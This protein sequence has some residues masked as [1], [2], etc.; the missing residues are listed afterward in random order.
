MKT[1]RRI[2]T[3]IL[4]IIFLICFFSESVAQNAI[5]DT[6]V[7]SPESRQTDSSFIHV[8]NQNH[9]VNDSISTDKN[10]TQQHNNDTLKQSD[11]DTNLLHNDTNALFNDTLE[12]IW[13]VSPNA[14]TSIVDYTAKDSVDFALDSSTVYL[15][16]NVVLNYEDINLTAY[17]VKVNFTKNELF[18]TGN[19]DSNGTLYDKPV[20]KQGSYEVKSHELSYNFESKKGLIRNVIT[21]EG[22][23][24]LHGEIVKKNPDNSSY[25]RK[26][27]YTTCNLENPHFEV[28]FGKAKVIPNDKIIT[29]PIFLKVASIPILPFPFGFFPHSEKHRNGIILPKFGQRIDM[30]PYLEGLGYYFALKEKVDV[31][32]LG[33]IYMRGSFAVRLSS[34]YVKRYKFNGKVDLEYIFTPTGERTTETFTTVHDI[35]VYWQHQQDRKAHPT[36]S[37]SA[38]VN[39]Q[40]HS[41]SKNTVGK[42]INDYTQSQA[43]SVISFSTMFKN[44]YSFGV[45]AELSQN[46]ILGNLDMRLPQINFNVSQFY[47]FRRKQVVGKLRW[48]ENI[49]MQYTLDVQN[50]INTYDSVLIGNFKHAFDNFRTGMNHYIPV[51]STIKLFK[52]L[53]WENSVALR[54]T[55]QIRGVKQSW[56]EYDSIQ[57]TNVRR[58][59]I[60]R[61]FPAHD[62]SLSSGLSTTLYGMYIMKKGRVYAFRHTITPSVSFTYRPS[63]NKKYLYDSYYDTIQNR[64]IQYSYINGFLYSVPAYKSSGSIN[65]SINNKLEMK[66]RSKKEDESF[67]KVTLIENLSVSLG[68]DFLADSFRLSTLNLSGR[69]TLFKQ[70]SLSVSMSFDPYVVGEDG[71]R[72]H[73]FEIKENHR[74]FRLSSTAGDVSFGYNINKELFQKKDDKENEKKVITTGFDQWNVNISYSFRYNMNDNMDFYRYARF[75]DTLIRKY[76]HRFT[77]SLSV[78]GSFDLTPKWNVRFQTGYNFTEKTIVP[79]EFHIERDLHCWI[80]SFNWIPFGTYRSFEVG[81]R[82]KANILRDAKY[83]QRKELYD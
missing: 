75:S 49:S 24:Y 38:N 53:N 56:G 12:N 46:I 15:Y 1:I 30:G 33:T 48:Y 11:N 40:T 18:S 3:V 52:Y 76:T 69:T 74:L 80:I 66:V 10:T 44:K 55:W 17:Y 14:V 59:T 47:P 23:S 19:T 62:L 71:Y 32:I 13:R 29:G 67:K 39:F 8:N 5:N 20:F 27:K 58:D 7:R 25:I 65:F 22:E 36:N 42:N 61:F 72:I 73:K 28:S 79:T 70:I 51:R 4:Q 45:N 50:T 9:I 77:N 35:K 54:E 63:I 26:G 78:S 57:R 21:Q 2:K 6:I 37:F 81:I 64:D 16:N 68:Y 31:T 60:F 43:T 83:D 34:N 82:A 41:F